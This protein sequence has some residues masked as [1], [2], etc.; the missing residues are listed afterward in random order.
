MD[1]SIEATIKGYEDRLEAVQREMV[2]LKLALEQADAR[3][4]DPITSIDLH[5]VRD[6]LSKQIGEID[7]IVECLREDRTDEKGA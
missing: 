2:R 1:Y 6:D 7:D 3:C 4:D 5:Q